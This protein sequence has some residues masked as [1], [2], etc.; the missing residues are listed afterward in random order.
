MNKEPRTIEKIDDDI[1][2]AGQTFLGIRL[3]DMLGRIVELDDRNLKNKL[4]EEYFN[5]QI[6]TYD[7]KIGGTRTRVNSAVRIIKAEKV[8]YAL[9]KIDGS[10][11]RV[12]P[13]AVV[14]AK[15]TIRKF[16]NG[17]II[18]PTL[19]L[20]FDSLTKEQI[21]IEI[22]RGISDIK[23]GRVYS[24]DAIEEEMKKDFNI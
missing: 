8:L 14:N 24:A 9:K 22:D 7:E 1:R 4:I 13:E 11:P 17:E 10:D 3:S 20:T 18:L 6:G 2:S 21:N 23:A 16:E 15:E 5:N 12:L 19:Q